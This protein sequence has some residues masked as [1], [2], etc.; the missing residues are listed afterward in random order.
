M[1]RIAKKVLGVILIILGFL[2]LI[3][4]LSPGSWLLLIGLEILG[5]RILLEDKL[6]LFL[7]KRPDSKLGNLMKKLMRV[8]ENRLTDSESDANKPVSK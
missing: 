6:I 8:R 4:P 3:T 1:K 2:A 7:N 5:L